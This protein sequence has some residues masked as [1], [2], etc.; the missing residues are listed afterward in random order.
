[1][2][3]KIINEIYHSVGLAGERTKEDNSQGIDNSS[4]VAKAYDFERVNALLAPRPT[5]SSESKTAWPSWSRSTPARRRSSTSSSVSWC[6]TRR[7]RRARPLRR[8]RD[9]RPPG[10]G[11]A[12]DTVR[13]QQ[14]E[15]LDR[16]AVP[17]AQEGAARLKDKM[18][19]PT[20][21]AGGTATLKKAGSKIRWP[22]PKP[23]D[24]PRDRTL[25]GSRKS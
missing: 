2:I 18:L 23:H 10:A 9:R 8:V 6:S 24:R 20:G 13:R 25:T 21:G 12:P 15:A 11:E 22:G 3:S 14:M 1:V 16:Q 5:A 17:A 4:G 7:L 19:D